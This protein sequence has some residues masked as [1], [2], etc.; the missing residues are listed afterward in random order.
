[1]SASG[2]RPGDPSPP[3]RAVRELPPEPG[4]PEPSAAVARRRM[5]VAGRPGFRRVPNANEIARRR[6][7][8]RWT[9][10]LLPA[11]AVMLLVSIA[12]WP[13]IDRSLNSARSA[14]QDAARV[15]V[16][17]GRLLG[18]RYHGL[19]DHDQPYTITAD[20]AQQG[21]AG[22]PGGTDRINLL[23]PVA[24]SLGSGGSWI[25]VNAENGVFM[26]HSQLLDLSRDVMLYRDDGIMAT[27]P[28]TDMDLRRG[29]VA[30]NDWVHVE[31][32]FGVMDAQG[33]L[34][35]QRDGIGQFRGPARLVLNDDHVAHAA[36]ASAAGR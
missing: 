31:G 13:E 33:Y 29:V 12:A 18:A 17:A 32:P 36:P 30:S 15:R 26:Q 9:K 8:L 21:R 6:R 2:D 14:M 1:M 27:G 7:L 5:S 22:Q 23:R 25:R 16:D 4:A 11:G 34:L 3:L 24:D 35:S 20:Q 28:V 10:W 19:D